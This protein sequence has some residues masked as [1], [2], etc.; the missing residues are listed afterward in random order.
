MT[1]LGRITLVVFLGS[2][3][4]GVPPAGVGSSSFVVQCNEA[5]CRAGVPK[6]NQ[7]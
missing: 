5:G 6:S 3:G 7:G 2:L 1:F 4:L